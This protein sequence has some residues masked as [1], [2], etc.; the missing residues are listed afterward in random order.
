MSSLTNL[1]R[2]SVLSLLFFFFRVVEE[3]A[4]FCFMYV[5]LPLSKLQ[6]SSSSGEEKGGE[7]FE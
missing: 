6:P 5:Q 7:G 3:V 4:A 1:L 2:Y